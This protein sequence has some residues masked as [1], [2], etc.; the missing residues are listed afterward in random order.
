MRRSSPLTSIFLTVLI[1]LL[2]FGIVLPLLPLYGQDFGASHVA[3][4]LLFTSFSAMQFLSAPF[5]GRLS[6]R[7]G[8]RPVVLVGLVGSFLSYLI[9]AVA[10]LQTTLA[11]LFVSRVLAGLFG[12]TISTAYAYI[13][14]V[15]P[16]EERGRGMALIG[17]AFGIGFTIGPA[18]GG[19]GHAI[20]PVVPGLAAAGFSLGAFLFALRRLPEPPRHLEAARRTWLDVG[21]FG[22]AM[23][24]AGVR[25]ILLLG[26]LTVTCFALMESTLG[27][28][29]KEHYAFEYWQVGVLFTYLGF[30]SALAQGFV[31][32]RYMNR[33]GEARFAVLGTLALAAGMG[34]LSFAPS[35]AWLAVVAPLA[36]LGFAMVTPSLNSLLS[37]RSGVHIQGGILGV[38]QSLQSLARIVGPM[39][40]LPLLGVWMP[41]PFWTGGAVMLAGLVLA[42]WLARHPVADQT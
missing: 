9:F 3:V 36:V 6:D 7:I 25:E 29:G 22:R 15:T 8:R 13:A 31:V 21:A 39:V 1:D 33:V 5:W 35:V 27:L 41:L 2:G 34:F 12:G 4:A 20:H 26:F 18:V 28:L 24:V 32:R 17:M 30:C 23:R 19:L 37:R 11:L 14:D 10:S 42:L 16:P 40:G 38:N